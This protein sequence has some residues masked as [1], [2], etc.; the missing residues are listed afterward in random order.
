[1]V[2]V[3]LVSAT[4]GGYRQALRS[5]PRHRHPHRRLHRQVVARE[6]PAGPRRSDRGLEHLHAA[7]PQYPD[8]QERRPFD[9]AE[10]REGA[11]A[12]GGALERLFGPEYE[13]VK[14]LGKMFLIA[15]VRRGVPT[16]VLR[17]AR[18][19]RRRTPRS[20]RARAAG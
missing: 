4:W 11:P 19:S 1:M 15:T 3:C 16:V 10:V 2:F 8:D 13:V 12:R 18:G 20:P 9:L 5:A 17:P 7:A 14:V 6:H